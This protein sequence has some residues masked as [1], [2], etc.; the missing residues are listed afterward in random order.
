MRLKSAKLP[1][2]ALAVAMT[3]NMMPVVAWGG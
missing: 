1:A 2:F 3:A